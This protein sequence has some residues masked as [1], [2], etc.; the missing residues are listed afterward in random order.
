[1]NKSPY[2]T[3][4]R[5]GPLRAGHAD[6]FSAVQAIGK[7]V[8]HDKR[9]KAPTAETVVLNP[10]SFHGLVRHT[11]IEAE[12]FGKGIVKV[13]RADRNFAINLP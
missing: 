9:T 8:A 3:G 7:H 6:T 13:P 2:F 4:F 10:C 1:M 11:G 12:E 5:P